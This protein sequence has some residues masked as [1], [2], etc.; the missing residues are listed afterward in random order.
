[1][2]PLTIFFISYVN[3]EC[4]KNVI[5]ESVKLSKLS[6]HV[7]ALIHE[8]TGPPGKTPLLSL[9]KIS[10]IFLYDS[11]FAKDLRRRS[12]PWLFGNLDLDSSQKK[13]P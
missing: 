2:E 6:V 4:R 12:G 9:P 1:M 11:R 8:P 10:D 13:V 7:V 5:L 3:K